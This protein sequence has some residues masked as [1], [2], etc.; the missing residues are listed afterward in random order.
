[1]TTLII[2]RH[3]NTFEKGEEPRRVGA[4]TDIPLVASGIE[5]ARQVGLYL[6]EKGV[7]LDAIYSSPLQRT[8]KSAEMIAEV[9]AFE[10]PITRLDIFKEIDYGPDENCTEDEVI[11]R[12][13]KQAIDAWNS[14]AKVPEG[15]HVNPDAIIANWKGFAKELVEKHPEGTVLVTTSN[16]I[17]RFSPHL[18]GDFA[19][20]AKNQPIKI[21]TGAL[22]LFRYVKGR[23]VIEEWNLKPA[24]VLK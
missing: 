14:D 24:Q 9:L 8:L 11:A 3:G 23:W 13:G 15:W 20:F 5:Q 4:K 6:K 18:T 17:A 19:S 1:M 2:V 22:C 7:V 16:G 12:V 21:S 10:A